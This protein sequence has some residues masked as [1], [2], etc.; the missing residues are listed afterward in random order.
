VRDTVKERPLPRVTLYR[1]RDH[2]LKNWAEFLPFFNDPEPLEDLKGGKRPHRRFFVFETDGKK[3]HIKKMSYLI[4]PRMRDRF[5]GFFLFPPAALLQFKRAL[6]VRAA[7]PETV[8]PFF[9][10]TRR[11]GIKIQGLFISPYSG[12]GLLHEVF[13]SG[14][15]SRDTKTGLFVKGI[16]DL[17]KM[18]K[19]GI[20][21]GD[22]HSSNI[23]VEEGRLLWCDFDMMRTGRVYLEFKGRR[24]DLYRFIRSAVAAAISRGEWNEPLKRELLRLC[25]ELYPKF[26]RLEKGIIRRLS[27]KFRE[28]SSPPG[29]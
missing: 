7:G 2:L 13:L 6:R 11:E 23:L 8:F 22:A 18:H 27:E 5:R 19:S 3:W 20:T 26:S 25:G 10:L 16:E 21:H 4:S 12:S 1:P 28:F 17:R 24:R 14:S 29:S 15:V 9:V